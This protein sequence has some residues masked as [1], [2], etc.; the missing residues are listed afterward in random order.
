MRN[1]D[2]C[3]A[4]VMGPAEPGRLVLVLAGGDQALALP[5]EVVDVRPEGF[6]FVFAA[7][8]PETLERLD[9]L[10]RTGSPG[11]PPA[12]APPPMGLRV[13]GE[14]WSPPVSEPTLHQWIPEKGPVPPTRGEGESRGWLSLPTLAQDPESTPSAVPA[15]APAPAAPAPVAAAPARMALPVR[16]AAPARAPSPA[17]EPQ[18]DERRQLERHEQSI[19]V[20][21]DNLTSLIKEFTHN[22][23]F[24]GMFVYTDRQLA[25][26]ASTVVTLIHP[27]TGE[28]L[29]LEARVAHC[30]KAP[31]PDPITGTQRF[32][33]G[34]EFTLPLERLKPLLSKFISA[35]QPDE[36]Q[37]AVSDV[38]GAARAVL[39]RGQTAAKLLGLP[40]QPQAAQVRAAYFALVDRFHPD[41]HYG[42]LS[43]AERQVLEELFRRL[44]KAYQELGA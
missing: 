5:G 12:S 31:S 44:T 18:G 37:P 1:L 33:V 13:A 43:A 32:G 41:R 35:H 7:L 29:S 28:R 42:K 9:L 23:S 16:A 8:P 3:G 11:A 40:E 36:A 20:A 27:V 22:I 15:A 2:T 14:D 25:K 34:L 10:L 21:F 38:V 17:A 39:A 4:F 24:G 19:P 26:L 30:G 6:A